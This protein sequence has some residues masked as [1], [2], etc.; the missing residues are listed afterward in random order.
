MN[1]VAWKVLMVL[2]CLNSLSGKGIIKDAKEPG[3]KCV[4]L[5]IQYFEKVL[6]YNSTNRDTHDARFIDVCIATKL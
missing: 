1:G 3:M 5:P 6:I 4:K 2:N